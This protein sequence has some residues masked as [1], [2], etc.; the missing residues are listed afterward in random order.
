MIFAVLILALG[1]WALG[2]WAGFLTFWTR[3]GG[4]DG[5][6]LSDL[7]ARLPLLLG[8]VGVVV[9]AN[10]VLEL[11][12]ALVPLQH[13]ALAGWVILALMTAGGIA[14]LAALGRLP[15]AMG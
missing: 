2:D 14:G 5:D 11:A 15:V 9:A 4:A 12:R 1:L 6:W 10:L 7:G 13:R 8:G 3:W